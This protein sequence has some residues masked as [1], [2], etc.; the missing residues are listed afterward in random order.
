MKAKFDSIRLRYGAYR[1]LS[2]TKER[3]LFNR[4]QQGMTLTPAGELEAT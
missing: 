2:G 4:T 3:L 1:N